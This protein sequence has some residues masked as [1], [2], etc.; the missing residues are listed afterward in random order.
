MRSG[1]GGL[2]SGAVCFGRAAGDAAGGPGVGESGHRGGR[3][4]EMWREGSVLLSLLDGGGRGGISVR[5]MSL[6]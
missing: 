5:G 4:A 2:V 6:Y 1:G 3:V